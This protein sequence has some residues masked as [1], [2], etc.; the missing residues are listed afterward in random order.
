MDPFLEPSLELCLALLEVFSR[1]PTGRQGWSCSEHKCCESSVSPAQPATPPECC[2][3][4]ASETGKLLP[5]LPLLLDLCLHADAGVA[6]ASAACIAGVS[7]LHPEDAAAILAQDNVSLPA[8]LAATLQPGEGQLNELAAFHLLH[9]AALA[10]RQPAFQRR[11]EAFDA[12][13][14]AARQ[15]LHCS[16]SDGLKQAASEALAVLKG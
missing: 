13:A 9:A 15:V 12:L 14:L 4:G 2:S 6:A 16:G 8:L 10:A 5:A 7:Q 1:R 11:R 3:A